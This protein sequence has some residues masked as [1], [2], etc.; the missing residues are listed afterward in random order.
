LLYEISSVAS[1]GLLVNF[2]GDLE[3]YLVKA[4]LNFV[5]NMT[6]IMLV[7]Q[8]MLEQV[9]KMLV[10]NYKQVKWVLELVVKMLEANYS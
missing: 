10:V 6:K 5:T 9:V 1:F 8:T 2:K 4:M 3:H 7:V